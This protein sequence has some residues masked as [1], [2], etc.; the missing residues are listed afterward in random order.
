MGWE[1]GVVGGMGHQGQPVALLES[2]D[3]SQF[4]KKGE[5]NQIL[6]GYGDELWT[7]SGLVA[8]LLLFKLNFS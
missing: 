7:W 1:S 3:P 2:T 4:F 6:K 8:S 5:K